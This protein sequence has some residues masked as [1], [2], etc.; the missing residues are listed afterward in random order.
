MNV[1]FKIGL[2]FNLGY[3]VQQFKNVNILTTKM[4]N[5]FHYMCVGVCVCLFHF[6]LFVTMPLPS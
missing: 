5:I 1:I 3:L 6:I 2:I 4:F